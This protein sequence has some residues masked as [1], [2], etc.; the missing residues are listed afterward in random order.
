MTGDAPPDENEDVLGALLKV[1]CNFLGLVIIPVV[2]I[3]YYQIPGLLVGGLLGYGLY[4]VCGGR[5]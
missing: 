3:Y 2:G 1:G 5:R 4:R